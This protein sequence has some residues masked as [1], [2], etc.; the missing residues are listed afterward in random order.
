LHTAG[1]DSANFEML[2]DEYQKQYK[3]SSS[4]PIQLQGNSIKITRCTRE[5]L[6][7]ALEHLIEIRILVGVAPAS[8]KVAPEFVRYKCLVEREDI[9]K[10]IDTRGHTDIKKWFTKS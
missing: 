2:Y 3:T 8:A 10:A 7:T 6:M 5:I 1:H 4:A 9:K